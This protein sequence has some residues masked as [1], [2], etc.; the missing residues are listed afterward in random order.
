MI[1]SEYNDYRL[2]MSWMSVPETM[3]G[4]CQKAITQQMTLVPTTYEKKTIRNDYRI[5]FKK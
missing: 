3:T 4:H 5:E 2:P 1:C